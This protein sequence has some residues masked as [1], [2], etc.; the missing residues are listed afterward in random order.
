MNKE[1]RNNCNLYSNIVAGMVLILISILHSQP[2]VEF[3]KTFDLGH[4][5]SLRD[6]FICSNGDFIACGGGDRGR[7]GYNGDFWILKTDDNGDETWSRTY[8]D[9]DISGTGY[10]V[11]ETED[12]NYLSAGIIENYAGSLLVDRDGNHVW[13]NI[14]GE[15]GGGFFAVIELKSGEY[16]LAGRTSRNPSI[17]Y[18]ICL[19]SDGEEI[20]TLEIDEGESSQFNAMRETE[21]GIVLAGNNNRWETLHCWFL[22]IDFDGEVIW[23]HSYNMTFNRSGQVRGMD[24]VSTSNG[25]F[26]V[27]G[28]IGSQGNSKYLL[29]NIDAEGELQW[30]E[31][32]VMPGNR[33]RNIPHSLVQ[34]D[35]S[36]FVIVGELNANDSYLGVLRVNQVGA[37]RWSSEYNLGESFRRPSFFTT[38]VISPDNSLIASGATNYRG[39]DGWSND[40]L[41][42]KLE[43]EY[44]E[45][46][47]IHW[48]PEDTIFS[49][50]PGDEVEFIARAI[51]QQG[52]ELTNLWIIDDDTLGSDTTEII[53]FDEL[54]EYLVSCEVS[55]G[56]FT[57]E[58]RWH[59]TAE[60]WYIDS[61][62]PDSLAWTVRRPYEADFSLGIR[63]L[64]DIEPRFRWILT[65]REH[66]QIDVGNEADLTYTFDIQGEYSLEGRAFFEDTEHSV[67]WQVAVNSVLYWWRPHERQ[68]EVEPREEIEFTVIPFNPDSDSLDYLWL[69][70]GEDDG[71]VEEGIF[72]RFN[73]VGEHS[74]T[75]IVHDG[76]EVDTVIWTITVNPNT[77][78]ED[79]T[80]LLSTEVTL[81]P[82]APNPFNSTTSIRYFLPRSADVRLTTY[83]SAG[84]LVQRLSEGFATSGEHRATIQGADLPA[85]VYLLR[86]ETGEVVRSMKV[87]L[88]K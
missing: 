16:I 57:T 31:S 60:E 5:E 67:I 22:K 81:Y 87:V 33:T 29:L 59:V 64:E 35:E 78:D 46:Q 23:N 75:A 80:S 72:A 62:S 38:V 71:D 19:D 6:I 69:V 52:D 73:D 34:V 61:Y 86:L 9:N 66:Q 68:L 51:D 21:G 1:I 37:T 47:F 10:S 2:A 20:W 3:V 82:A 12:G 43:H 56:E 74:V 30:W 32:Y 76:A 18:V 84:R 70:D 26:A 85:G 79:Q 45:P 65:N 11:I 14:H 40:G 4:S 8:E 36:D 42:V 44:L 88:L 24:L 28:T 54:G 41:I 39:E 63:A 13:S 55:D 15:D 49:V 25:G 7:G 53:A 50:L 48:A 17:G 58:I 83:D 27:S 77:V